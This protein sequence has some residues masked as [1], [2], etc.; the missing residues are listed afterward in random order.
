MQYRCIRAGYEENFSLRKQSTK[1][2]S[3]PAP[4]R[5]KTDRRKTFANTFITLCSKLD[6]SKDMASDR[7]E[8]QE[9]KDVMTSLRKKMYN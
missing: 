3:L 5:E 4:H 7:K 8:H 9:E 6:P 2:L 1:T